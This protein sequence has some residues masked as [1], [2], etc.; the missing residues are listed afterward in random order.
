MSLL[1]AIGAES[2][3]AISKAASPGIGESTIAQ[4]GKA[5]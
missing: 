3:F 1:L 5:D 2:V 4:A